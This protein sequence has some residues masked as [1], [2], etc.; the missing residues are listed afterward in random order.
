MPNI[1]LWRLLM[2]R[3]LAGHARSAFTLVEL[4]VVISIIALLVALLLPALGQARDVSKNLKCKAQEHHIALAIV[5]YASDSNGYAPLINSTGTPQSTWGNFAWM[6]LISPYVNG[7]NQSDM[8]AIYATPGSGV[9]W[10]KSPSAMMKVLQCPS[11]W[12]AFEMWGY[13]SYGINQNITNES[14]IFTFLQWPVRLEGSKVQLRQSELP[15]V[16]ESI[17]YNQ[18]LPVWNAVPLY[19]FLHVQRR[20]YVFGDGHVADSERQRGDYL[21]GYFWNTGVMLGGRN[22]AVGST[23]AATAGNAND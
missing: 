22:N 23:V 17:A 3:P 10:I 19:P 5:N 6:F 20:N 15:L 4:L 7:P 12:K 8:M 21:M 13:N 11:T 16:A 9:N 14:S 18:I 2:P 1:F